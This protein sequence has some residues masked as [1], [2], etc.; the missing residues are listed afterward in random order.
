MATKTLVI[1]GTTPDRFFLAVHAGT[2]RVGDTPAHPEATVQ[3]LRVVRV[4]CEVEVEEDR[5]SLPVEQAGVIAPPVLRAGADVRLTHATVA[6]RAPEGVAA[7]PAAPDAPPA[8][9]APHTG[10][11]WLKVTDGADQGEWFALPD[12]GTV[13]VGKTGHAD[14]GLN[15]LYVA[16]VHCTLTAAGGAVTVAHVEGATGTLV[17]NKRIAQPQAL[18]PGSV[19]RVGNSHLR[20]E[21]GPFPAAPAA[22]PTT[23]VKTDGTDLARALGAD[24]GRKGGSAVRPAPPADDPFAE[25]VGHTV[26][27]FHLDRLLARGHLG[28]VFHATNTKTG[29]PAAVRVLPPEFP[30]APAE[31]ERFTHELKALQ[32]VRHP[33]LAGL[34]GAGKTATH[35]WVAREHVEGESAADVVARLSEGEKPSWTRAAR[36]VTHLMRA[37]DCLHQHRLTHGNITPRTVLLASDHATKL[38][39]LRL[40]QMLA[41]SAFGRK[42]EKEALA[43]MPYR[44]PEQVEAGGF[45][46]GLA[47]LYAAGAVAYALCTGNRPFRGHTAAEVRDNI[48]TGHVGKPSFV[49]KKVPPAFDAVVLKLTARNQE[50]RYQTAAAVLADLAPI[51]AGHDLKL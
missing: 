29:Q 40:A 46:D 10:P 17:D 2:L 50:D 27:H 41:G 47:D 25:L 7:A 42:S 24:G 3:H 5:D 35:C 51:A 34:L 30:A 26:G 38:T 1:D 49:Y 44:A 37:L 23:S 15:D 33:N 9:D 39:D 31:L 6:L 16:R 28:A 48:L 8:P 22:A 13:T 18:R 21:V 19:L 20:L 43:D 32:P 11:R 14:V 4:R 36:V 12:A 45:V